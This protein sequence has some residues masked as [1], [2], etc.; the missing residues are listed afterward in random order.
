MAMS[1]SLLPLHFVSLKLLQYYCNRLYQKVCLNLKLITLLFGEY[2]LHIR[3][4]SIL[5]SVQ[6]GV[7]ICIC[8]EYI[9]HIR[10]YSILCS[11]QEGVNICICGEY[12]LHTRL[13]SILCSAQ[14]GVNIC[15]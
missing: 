12:I 15:I 6:E 13:Y 14:E 7:N 8:G 5:C 4:Y 10:L 3:L 9:L 1:T 2:I 11:A